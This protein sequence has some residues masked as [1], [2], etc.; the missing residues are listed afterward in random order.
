MVSDE[1]RI[2]SWY[3]G[4]EPAEELRGIKDEAIGA[5]GIG[6][7]ASQSVDD[8]TVFAQREALLRERCAQT[9]AAETF[10]R[11]AVMGVDGACSVQGETCKPGIKRRAHSLRIEPEEIEP[12]FGQRWFECSR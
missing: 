5:I 2:G 11:I 12:E 7:W 10:E 9:V 1:V 3:E 8:A 6:P 4:C